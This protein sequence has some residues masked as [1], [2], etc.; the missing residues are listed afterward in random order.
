[1]ISLSMISI[2]PAQPKSHGSMSFQRSRFVDEGHPLSE[3]SAKAERSE[4]QG[5]L[6]RFLD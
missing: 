6:D 3:G 4:P 2:V 1:M 5:S